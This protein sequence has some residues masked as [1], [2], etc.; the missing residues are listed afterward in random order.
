MARGAK[1]PR[2]GKGT[3]LSAWGPDFWQGVPD[4]QIS[5]DFWQGVP[6]I[7]GFGAGGATNPRI[8]GMGCQMSYSQMGVPDFLAEGVPVILGKFA[9]GCQGDLQCYRHDKAI[10]AKYLTAS[11]L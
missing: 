8:F 5:Y 2:T 11:H 3:R 6:N 7:L 4:I 1:Y 9:L 10:A